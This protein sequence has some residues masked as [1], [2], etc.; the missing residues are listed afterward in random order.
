M[1]AIAKS[2]DAR[3]GLLAVIGAFFIWGGLPLYLR[4]LHE[5]NALQIM[6][7]RLVWCCLF[8]L[9]WL[10]AQGQLAKVA[11]ALLNP[12]TRWRLCASALLVSTN[13]LIYVWAVG[14]GHVLEGSLGY[15]INP[16]VNVLFGVLLL[17]ERLNRVQWTAVVFAAAGVAYLT[18]LSGAPPWIA[19]SLAVSFS[20]YG[21]IRKTVAVDAV[22]GLGAETLLL[23]PLGLGYLVWTE[24]HGSGV[25]GHASLFLDLWLALGGLVTA[26]PLALFAYG[27]RRIPYSTVGVCQ[28]LGPTLQL[29]TGVFLFH[30]PFT[31]ARA[32]GFILI[33]T[34]LVIYAGD[35]IWRG[36]RERRAQLPAEPDA[37][38]TSS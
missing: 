15:F 20:G 31:L 8:V 24:L 35:G 16:L 33:W 27:A 26:V 1:D 18:W 32:T 38:A 23:T 19:L 29:L 10:T 11:A 22:T 2:T 30:E 13:W 17:S 34:A 14:N 37:A 7:H 28:Y 9:G 3:R 12:A 21:L 25:F 6:S 4:P 36:Q 5:I